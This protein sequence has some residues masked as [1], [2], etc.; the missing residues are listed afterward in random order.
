MSREDGASDLVGV[1]LL[2]RKVTET[3]ITFEETS[4]VSL[5]SRQVGISL[6][7]GAL[8]E[9]QLATR[10]F[11]EEV[12]TARRIQQQLLPETPPAL[13]G[14]DVC[15][16]NSPSR[17]VGGD[18]HDFLPLPDNRVG[19]AIGDVSGKGVPA[20]LLMSN[21]QAALRVRALGWHPVDRVVQDVN[22]QICRNTGYGSFISFFLGDLEPSEG[23]LSFVN[24]GHNAPLIVRRDGTV[25][26]LETGGLLLGVFPEASYQ[27]G[28]VRLDPGDVLAMYTDGVTE[29]W[30]PAGDMFSEDRLVQT[31]VRHRD[32]SAAELH[33]TVLAEVRSFQQGRPP[34]DDLTLVLLKRVGG[35][36]GNGASV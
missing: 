4:L 35:G 32:R 18:Y 19:L 25:E 17:Q 27:R 24:A 15:A 3:R 7:N 14:W 23:R 33:D 2:G 16:S 30:S 22:R 5:I 10:L 36:H 8:H 13:P 11:E 34:D 29:A 12:A 6:V 31:L 28:E 1:L 9:E 26:P 21:L 20:A